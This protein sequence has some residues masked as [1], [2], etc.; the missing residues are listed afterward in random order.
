MSH[1]STNGKPKKRKKRSFKP[2]PGR[3][4]KQRRDK[5]FCRNYPCEGRKRCK[6]HGGAALRGDQHPNWKGGKS[7][8]YIQSHLP[9]RLQALFERALADPELLSLRG[10]LALTKVRQGE[11]EDQLHDRGNLERWEDLAEV[12]PRVQILL[13]GDDLMGAQKALAHCV[14]L[15]NDARSDRVTWE[16]IFNV[17]EHQRKL[18]DTERK[19]EDHLQA[20]VTATQFL[21]VLAY[22]QR[23]VMEIVT[24]KKQIVALADSMRQVIELGPHNPDAYLPPGYEGIEVGK[25]EG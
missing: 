13:Q 22:F 14:E 6:F 9:P 18:A 7:K 24:D 17:Q 20:H 21:A 23:R 25:E 2:T 10:Q 11:L 3:C 5:S 1:T 15:V 8:S 4:N 19:R 12:L 16:E